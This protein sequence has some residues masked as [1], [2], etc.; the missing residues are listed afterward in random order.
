[1]NALSNQEVGNY[2]ATHFVSSFQK[3]GTFRIDGGRKQ[4]GNVA[5]Y[6]VTGQ[7][8]VLHVLAGPVDA[9]TF[10]REA[11]WAVETWKLSVLEKH[12]ERARKAFFAKAH[13]DRLYY[14]HDERLEA[15]GQAFQ[16]DSQARKPDLQP[17]QEILRRRLTKQAQV[18]VLLA[19]TPLAR[20][21]QIYGRVFEDILGEKVSSRPVL[22]ER[23]PGGSS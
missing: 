13:A 4:G 8:Q 14:E 10:L 15:V 9:A 17:D 11:R 2:L 18:H 5:S 16:P 19:T 22:E 21:E 1:V 20:I 7:G 12:D 6:F 23:K 3:I